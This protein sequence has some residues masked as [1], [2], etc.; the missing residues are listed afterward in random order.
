MELVNR[1]P[2]RSWNE[3][4]HVHTWLSSTFDMEI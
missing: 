1:R 3:A 4:S 2:C